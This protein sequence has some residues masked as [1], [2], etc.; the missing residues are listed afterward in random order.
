MPVARQRRT[1][2][3]MDK[4]VAVFGDEDTSQRTRVHLVEEGFAT[5]RVDVV[6]AAE[7]GR[8]V[9]DPKRTREDDLIAH[10]TM[11]FDDENDLS[12]VE[13]IVGCIQQGKGVVVV[14]PRGKIE[15]GQ[16]QEIIETHQP[17]TVFWRVA[18]AEAQGGLLGEHAAGFQA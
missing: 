14:H 5:D 8:V 7:D 16:A 13:R 15:I 1:L 4:I 12:L 11:I 3:P 2:P 17:E 6:S 18:P 9:R 10:F